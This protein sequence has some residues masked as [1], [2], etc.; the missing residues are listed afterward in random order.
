MYKRISRNE[1][2]NTVFEA[3]IELIET[4][5]QILKQAYI[6]SLSWQKDNCSIADLL[7]GLNKYLYDLRSFDVTGGA[8]N[9]VRY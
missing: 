6:L 3:P 4:Y 8:K 7:V 5:L 9:F 2:E 1:F